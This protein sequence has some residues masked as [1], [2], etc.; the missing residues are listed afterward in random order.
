VTIIEPFLR[1]SGIVSTWNSGRY[2][3]IYGNWT[4]RVYEYTIAD[5]F[6]IVP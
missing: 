5:R 1:I 6:D 3:F 4:Q 2:G